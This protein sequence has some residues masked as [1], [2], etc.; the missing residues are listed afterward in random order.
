MSGWP[1][2]ELDRLLARQVKDRFRARGSSVTVE[3]KNIG[4][5]L[6]W[7]PPFRSTSST[8]GSGEAPADRRGRGT[9]TPRAIVDRYGYL[10]QD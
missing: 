8:H 6:R 1:S 4:Y 2:F 9:H 5:E 7:A 3:G 10:A